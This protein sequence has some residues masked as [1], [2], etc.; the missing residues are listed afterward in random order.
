MSVTSR[1]VSVAVDARFR[2]TLPGPAMAS[3]WARAGVIHESEEAESSGT[4]LK[5]VLAFQMSDPEP[6]QVLRGRAPGS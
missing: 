1:S 6:S 3:G 4:Q 2:S 5:R